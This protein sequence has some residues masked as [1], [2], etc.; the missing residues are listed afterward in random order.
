VI[1]VT[2][3]P[4]E[5]AEF[6]TTSLHRSATIWEAKGAYSHETKWVVMSAL[7]RSQAVFLRRWLKELDPQAFILITNSSEI[8]GKG[9]LRA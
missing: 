1:L 3:F 8:F 2:A 5:V 6:I 4:D 9:F 7:S